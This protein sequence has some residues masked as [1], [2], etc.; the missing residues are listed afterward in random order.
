MEKKYP[1]TYIKKQTNTCKCNSYDLG[2]K[3]ELK[4]SV[5]TCFLNI[6]GQSCNNMTPDHDFS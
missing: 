2:V 3:E 4:D 5:D 6:M 1:K